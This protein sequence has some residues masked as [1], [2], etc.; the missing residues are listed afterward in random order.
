M[1]TLTTTSLTL[2]DWAK[3]LDPDGKT[4]KVVELLNQTNEI[5]DDMTFIEGNLPTGHLFTQRTGLPTVYFKTINAGVPSSKST[6]VQL[7]EQAAMLRSFSQV[8]ADL[9]ELNGNVR[10]FRLSEA[11]AFVEAMS[12][13]MATTIFNGNQGT[14]PEQFTGLAPRY[15]STTA[16]NGSNIIL[17]GG[18]GSDNASIY[19][20]GWG[21][22]MV[23]GIFPKGSK[24][25]IEHNDRG[26]ILIQNAGGTT[27]NFMD[28]YVDS[29]SWNA[30][31][32]VIDWRYCVRIPNIDISNL[33]A[34][35]SAADL[36][37]L[38]IKAMHRIPSLKNC[39]P[40]FYMNRTCFQMLDI[41][42]RAAVSTGG[43][44]SYDVVDGKRMTS[45]RGIPIKV[46]DALTETEAVVS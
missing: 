22:R 24:A 33:V 4:S 36:P 29:W 46:C 41:E 5:L 32:A 26:K 31:L 37:V 25:G 15:S 3:R 18:S 23:T 9:A 42:C 30:G 8:D 11:Q 28:A 27:G 2:L 43:Q 19:L 35:S 10:A 7:T 12:Q 44:L 38:M 17:G 20:V 39:K 34:Q 45:F 14:D 21:D 6:T 16:G 13:K 40:V 1:A